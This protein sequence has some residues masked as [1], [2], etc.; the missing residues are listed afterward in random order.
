MLNLLDIP[1]QRSSHVQPTPRGAGIA[2]VMCVV[3]GLAAA[4]AY[5][6]SYFGRSWLFYLFGA[7]LVANVS[8]LDDIRGAPVWLR[9]LVHVLAALVV[10]FGVGYFRAVHLPLLGLVSLGWFGPALTLVWLVGMTNIYNFMDGID[11]LAGN[12]ALIAGLSWLGVGVLIDQTALAVAGLL[13]V[14]SNLGFL[15]HNWPPASIFM[16]DI[17]SAFLGFTL[18]T[19]TLIAG[20]YDDRLPAIGALFIWPFLFDATATIISRLRRRENIFQPHRSHFYQR[21]VIGGYS[22]R[23]VTLLYSYLALTG[24]FLASAWFLQIPGSEAAIAVLTPLMALSLWGFV[25]RHERRLAAKQAPAS[26]RQAGSQP[27]T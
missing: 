7:L 14:T 9:F 20:R 3:M 5:A 2:I 16:G 17:G 19:L 18:A 24:V 4:A 26:G 6:P 25:R 21:L 11:G 1:G 23:F 12:Q 10:I 27:E 22:H 13:L 8:W 15:V